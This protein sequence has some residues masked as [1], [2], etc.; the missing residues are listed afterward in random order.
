MSQITKKVDWCINKAKKELQETG[1]HRGLIKIEPNK[2]Q[3]KMYLE[4]AQHNLNAAIFFAQHGYSDWS[5]S[6]FFYCVY[7]CFLSILR[8]QGYESRNQECTLA[9]IEFLREEK[10]INLEQK[11]ID[12]FLITKAKEINLSMIEIRED[13]QYGV[14]QSF[15]NNTLFTSLLET[16]KE[17]LEKTRIIVYES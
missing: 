6:A 12:M 11:F 1:L 2:N 8:K 16:C 4:K 13:F 10:M 3:A 5:A 7:H 14:E 17:V 15:N 9:I